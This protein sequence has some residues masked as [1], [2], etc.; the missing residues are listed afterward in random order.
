MSEEENIKAEVA[1]QG[2]NFELEQTPK[3]A[4][5]QVFQLIL[6]NGYETL[7]PDIKVTKL[8]MLNKIEYIQR[9]K[10]DIP[11]ETQQYWPK[12]SAIFLD[13]INRK[14]VTFRFK[15]YP[16]FTPIKKLCH[17]YS[18][19]PVFSEYNTTVSDG[20]IITNID[21]I[22]Q[23]ED[24]P[25]FLA[26]LH[27]VYQ[28]IAKEAADLI[29]E[30][31]K[32]VTEEAFNSLDPGWK[33]KIY[34]DLNSWKEHMIEKKECQAAE[35]PDDCKAA[36]KYDNLD[37]QEQQNFLK[38]V[39]SYQVEVVSESLL[40]YIGASDPKFIQKAFSSA[41][42]TIAYIEAFHSDKLNVTV[43]FN[44]QTEKA[45]VDAFKPGYL[46][47]ALNSLDGH[48]K[49]IKV[50]TTTIGAALSI[51]K[52]LGCNI[53]YFSPIFL[54]LDF[55]KVLLGLA[56]ERMLLFSNKQN[57]F[58]EE[59]EI[60]LTEVARTFSD[61]FT[62][63]NYNQVIALKSASQDRLIEFNGRFLYEVIQSKKCQNIVDPDCALLLLSDITF[64]NEV[65]EKNFR[66][67]NL[68]SF[69]N[70]TSITIADFV[71]KFDLSFCYQ[72][73]Q[74]SLLDLNE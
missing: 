27:N 57:T 10:Y 59:S 45:L 46:E 23:S 65:I 33:D 24:M 1:V 26:H 43:S 61:L 37:G 47:E 42:Q 22:L 34:R 62:L 54:A 49:S 52:K 5:D 17:L 15:N 60:E 19:K 67:V 16:N 63:C 36:K 31:L 12:I 2:T 30:I 7:R 9:K 48:S 68:L 64:V 38:G 50:R 8:E 41:N 53:P 66:A 55:S 74:A 20:T 69:D 70:N 21:M 13:S 40:S 11:L 25:Y 58:T 39:M 29:W 6:K 73:L 44:K 14:E 56:S 51:S 32:D 4:A 72:S 3:N 71:V 35:Q 28:A 18:I